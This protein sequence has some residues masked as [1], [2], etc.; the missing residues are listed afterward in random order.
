LKHTIGVFFFLLGVSCSLLS[1]LSPFATDLRLLG[2]ADAL[3]FGV[4][5][6]VGSSLSCFCSLI[7]GILQDFVNE[8]TAMGTS[9]WESTVLPIFYGFTMAVVS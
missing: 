8:L 3:A 2:V 7:S 6:T 9:S 5:S 4:E 1:P